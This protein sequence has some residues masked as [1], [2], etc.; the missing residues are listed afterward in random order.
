MPKK[1]PEG[2]GKR[3]PLNMR[4]TRET[5]DRLEKAA[6]ESGRSLAQEVEIRLERSF[7]FQS[8]IEQTIRASVAM[9]VKE[10]EEVISQYKQFAAMTEFHM[11]EIAGGDDLFLVAAFL[12]RAIRRVEA[13]TGKTVRED[14]ATREEA[15]KELLGA[16]PSL[17][18][19]LPEPYSAFK[20]RIASAPAPTGALAAVALEGIAKRFDAQQES[21]E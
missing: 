6:D 4:T 16:I 18:R 11:T 19:K 17:F 1:L 20:A 8:I 7:D 10:A 15:E 21:D 3:V 14:Q 5:R 12:S 13:A 2:E 9:S